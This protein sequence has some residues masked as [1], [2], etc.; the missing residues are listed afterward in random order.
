MKNAPTHKEYRKPAIL[1][2]RI[3]IIF[4]Y[5]QDLKPAEITKTLNKKKPKTLSLFIKI[6]IFIYGTYSYWEN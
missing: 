6:I 4:H 3:G 2:L 5:K 1:P